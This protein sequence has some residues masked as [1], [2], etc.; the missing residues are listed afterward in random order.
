MSKSL[1]HTVF[2]S[3][4]I[5]AWMGSP[6]STL[7]SSSKMRRT[8]Y[9]NNCAN[10]D[11]S[12]GICSSYVSSKPSRNKYMRHS[13]TYSDTSSQT[14]QYPSSPGSSQPGTGPGI[15]PDEEWNLRA[16]RA[17]YTL[18]TTLPTFFETG[19]VST[20]DGNADLLN[21][22]SCQA[23]PEEAGEDQRSH[24]QHVSESIYAPNIRLSY[25]PPSTF[26][27]P[28]AFPKTLQ[29]EGLPLYH[30]SASFVRHTLSAFNTELHVD[31]CK[32]QVRSSGARQRQIVIRTIVGGKS[33]LSGTRNEWDIHST[34]TLSPH[35]GLIELH[36][37]E[38]IHPAPHVTF[39]DGLRSALARLTGVDVPR[40]AND[41]MR[42]CNSDRKLAPEPIRGK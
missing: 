6:R 14:S 12:L 17:I 5:S 3:D 41:G 2:F 16:G 40:Q 9:Q 34:Y 26:T 33:R 42:G 18:K 19:L 28:S 10:V 27:L 1:Y 11:R 36:V 20:V 32:L 22:A 25:T 35:S 7:T 38:S 29:V 4:A 23:T 37:V 30:A 21:V 24:A 15:L 31:L 8:I 39:Y 13:A